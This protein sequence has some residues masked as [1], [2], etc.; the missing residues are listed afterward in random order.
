MENYTPKIHKHGQVEML[1]QG[2]E[3]YL[4]KRVMIP[5]DDCDLFP[6]YFKV[7][8]E[9]QMKNAGIVFKSIVKVDDMS[10]CQV[11]ADEGKAD[12]FCA[13]CKD[14]KSTDKIEKSIGDPPE[15]LC[16][17]CYN[18]TTAKIWDNALKELEMKHRYDYE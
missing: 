12:F 5:K 13:L 1:I 11:C 10:I 6:R 2:E 16:K 8:Q 7:S 17:D 9:A 18:T 4:C 15:F 3:C 14:R